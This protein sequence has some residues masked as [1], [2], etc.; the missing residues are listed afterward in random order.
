MSETA[1][2][3]QEIASEPI[4]AH[5]SVDDQG[6]YR[7]TVADRALTILRSSNGD[8]TEEFCHMVESFRM[9]TGIFPLPLQDLPCMDCPRRTEGK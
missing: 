8:A 1:A 6:Q 5:E 9:H 3:S 4:S 2:N 7:K